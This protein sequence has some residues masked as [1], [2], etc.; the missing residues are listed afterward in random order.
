ML[1]LD[2]VLLIRRTI[3]RQFLTIK[4]WTIEKVKER[5]KEKIKAN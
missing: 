4:G 5:P 1:Y 2:K 3:K